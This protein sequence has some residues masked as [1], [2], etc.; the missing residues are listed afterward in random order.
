[1]CGLPRRFGA[2]T[3]QV[4]RRQFEPTHQV[5]DLHQRFQTGALF[6]FAQLARKSGI[7]ALQSIAQRK[8][9][10]GRQQAARLH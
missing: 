3:P 6:H 8:K 4:C 2:G 5:P 1:L 9:S 10:P 7:E